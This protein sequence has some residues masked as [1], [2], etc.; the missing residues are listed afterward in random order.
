MKCLSVFLMFASLA[1]ASAVAQGTKA[2]DKASA[3]VSADARKDIQRHRA[4]AAA[5]ESA[6]KCLEGGQPEETCHKALQAAC[7]GIAI[8]KHCGM[9]HEH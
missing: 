9:R 7:K 8:G 1:C 5:H 2:A 4:I 6:A 3:P